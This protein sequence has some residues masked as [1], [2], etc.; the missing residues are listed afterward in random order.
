MKVVATLG[1]EQSHAWQVASQYA[2]D[3]EIRIYPHVSGVFEAFSNGEAELAIV[4]VYNTREGEN[5]EY[6]R[7]L[8]KL[9]SCFW[10]DNIVKPTNLSLGVFDNATGLKQLQVLLGKRTVFRQ[11]E[12]YLGNTF[13]DI[14]LMSVHDLDKTIQEVREQH[15]VGRGVIDS[16]EMLKAHGLH[17]LEREVAAHNRTRYAVLGKEQVGRTGYDATAFVTL[18]LDDRVGILVDM[19]NEFSQRG[20]NILDM[21]SENDVKTQKLQIHMEVEGH[22]QD[23]NVREA[24]TQVENNVIQQAGSIKVLGSFPRI[25]MRTKYINSLGFIGTGSMSEWFA[26]RLKSEGYQVVMTGRSTS[27]RPEEMIPQVDV[28]VICVPISVT[29]Q[30]IMQYGPFVEEGKA[31]ILLAGESE[32]TLNAAL[33]STSEGVEVMLVHNLWGPQA[34]TMKDKNAI[35]VRSSRSGRLCSEFEA[36]LYKHGATIYHDSAGKHDL[37]MGIGQKLPTMISVALAM[38]LED[39]RITN[40][41]ISGHCTLTSLYPIL[42][43]ARVHSQNSRTYAEIM[44]TKGDSERIVLDFIRNLQKVIG[45]ATDAGISDLCSL[46][47]QNSKYLTEDFLRARMTQAKALDDI[48]GRMI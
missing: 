38:T 15:L 27:L 37:L 46:I 2:P 19:L 48:L 41:D 24:V 1:P 4:P 45:L 12:E 23:K 8:W 25:D 40:D 5:K 42:A 16:E 35:V 10:I 14:S 3:A 33:N 6:F 20:I 32:T 34:A 13:Q 31:L 17:I 43:M 7:L 28:V 36:F 30:T 26:D 22:I 11:C 18:P 9:K 47:D 39:N 29:S 21:R 44:S